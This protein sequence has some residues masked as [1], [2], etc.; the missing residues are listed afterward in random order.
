[1]KRKFFT[2]SLSAI[3]AATCA[4]T[5]SACGNKHAHAYSSEIIQPTCTEKGYTLHSC[6]CGENYRDNYTDATGHDYEEIE[7]VAPDCV[8][9]GYTVYACDCGDSYED[10]YTDALGHTEV[11]DKAVEASCTQSGLTEGIHC[12]ECDA[13]IKEQKVLPAGH[14][15]K[16][17]KCVYCG[18]E[19]TA[20]KLE[21]RLNEDGTA[22]SVAG[23]GPFSDN[24]IVIPAE[25]KGLPVTAIDKMAFENCDKITSITIGQNVAIIGANA[26]FG[27]TGITSITI[28]DSVTEIAFA[29]FL[30]CT[31]ITSVTIP[32][33]VT[34]IGNNAFSNCINLVNITIPDGITS[35]ENGT[36]SGCTG[37]TYITIPDG[38]TS[39][40]ISTFFGC[41]GLTSITIPD[42]VT[43]INYSAFKNCSNLSDV[44]YKGREQDWA[45]INIDSNNECLLNAVLHYGS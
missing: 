33:G 40:G 44:Y 8:N 9:Q 4:L 38:V 26:F 36:F 14:Y 13:V 23:L 5:L 45:A 11:I 31:G 28:P 20:L 3:A 21:Y 10:N 35:I 24:E 18:T 39:I 32:Y 30:G 7:T 37:L 19:S 15:I 2:V 1:M 42:S 17:G 43:E 12:S 6:S 25:Y 34:S 16:D 27:C 22:Y 41:T 29:A